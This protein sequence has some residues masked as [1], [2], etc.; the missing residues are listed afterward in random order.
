MPNTAKPAAS[1]S[2]PGPPYRRRR[3]YEIKIIHSRNDMVSRGSHTHQTPH[4][5]RAQSGPVTIAIAPYSTVSSAAAKAIQSYAGFFLMR[6]I[7][8]TMPQKIADRSISIA[9][10]M[11]K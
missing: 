8:L 1:I 7:A 9:G 4:A 5:F 6:N 10:G 2:D 3:I 11:W